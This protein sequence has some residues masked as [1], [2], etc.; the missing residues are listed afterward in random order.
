MGMQCEY[1]QAE[2]SPES[3]TC[4]ACGAPQPQPVAGFDNAVEI[5][6]ILKDVVRTNGGSVLLQTGRFI[7]L[8]NDAL[9]AYDKERRLL[10]NMLRAGILRNM[11]DEQ[12]DKQ[13]A[14]MR[15]VSNMQSE[16]FIIA[17]AVE[18]VAVCF[19]YV[20][21]WKYDASMRVSSAS[22]AVSAAAENPAAAAAEKPAAPLSPDDRVFRPVDA[23]KSRFAR[24]VTVP[25]GFTKLESFCFDR[26]GT[27]RS[28]V[29]PS[30]LLA[31]GEYAFSECKHL[32]AAELPPS[33]KLIQQ[34]AFS[35]CV[36]LVVI[37]IPEGVLEIADNTFLCCQSL[38][39]AEIPST[40]TSVG[41]NA[42]SGCGKLT[43]LFLHD[44]VK[45]IAEDAFLQCPNLTVGCYENSYVHKYCLSHNMKFETTVK[46][47]VI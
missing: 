7:A 4:P 9:P 40:V 27:M 5:Q 38:E 14:V 8:I 16:C 22:A 12:H 32:K 13:L 23:L 26:F 20:L 28:V 42:F 45:Y 25:E 19:T 37:K 36:N 47:A 24:N 35:Q 18:F 10:V 3:L 39:V 6:K 41:A 15:A 31:I 44:S 1:C 43:K 30:T 46:D 29:L 21:G 11:L 17:G 2:L 34:G 33:L